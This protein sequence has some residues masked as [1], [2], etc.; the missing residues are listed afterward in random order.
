MLFLGQACGRPVALCP[1]CWSLG[2]ECWTSITVCSASYKMNPCVA[3][4]SLFAV[5]LSRLYWLSCLWLL[6]ILLYCCPAFHKNCAVLSGEEEEEEIV[7]DARV[8]TFAQLKQKTVNRGLIFSVFCIIQHIYTSLN[9]NPLKLLRCAQKQKYAN[10]YDMTLN[11]Q[12][13]CKLE[14]ISL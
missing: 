2:Q 9:F 4:F 10:C 1:P 7:I 6:R 11:I 5:S 12:L 14:C 13:E 3:S 8:G